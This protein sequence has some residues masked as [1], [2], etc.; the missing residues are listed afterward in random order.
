M[1]Q[2]V[3]PL[4][5]RTSEIIV[6]GNTINENPAAVFRGLGCVT[7]NG[8]SRLLMD[9]KAKHPEVYEEILRQLFAPDYGA[10]LTHI[11]VEFGADINSS[12]GTE[13]CVKRSADEVPDV[14]R[15]AG[16][17]LAADAKRINPAVTADLLRWG[18]PHWVTEAFE[19]SKEAG[20]AAR[21]RWFYETLEAA[22]HTY[23]LTFDYISPDANETGHADVE[24]LL[25]FSKA[26]REQE[27]PPY[28]FSAIRLVASDEVGS[29][30]IAEEK[31]A[32]EALRDAVDVIGLHYTTYGDDN[33]Q[34]LHDVYGKEIWYSEGIAPCNVP[35]L[36]CRADGCG[37]AGPNGPI[38][39]A[40]RII[41]SYVHGRMVMYEFQPAVSAYYDGAC[42]SPKQLITANTPWSGHF[43]RDIGFWIAS[44][45]TCFAKAGWQYVDSACYGDGEEN[46]AIWNTTHNF[47]TLV[48][49]DRTDLTMHISNDSDVP[50]SYLVIISHLPELKRDF[51]FVETAGCSNPQEIDKNWFRLIEE[52]HVNA[53]KGD[54]AFP[55]VVK[56]HSLLTI[57]T[58]DT[59]AIKEKRDFY[60]EFPKAKRLE[61]PYRD[62]FD[63]AEDF[64]AQR[65]GA[66]F[67]TTDQ[68][69]AFEVVKTADGNVLQQ[70]ITKD[71]LPTNW[72]FRGTPDPITC[73]GDDKW[74]NYQ[75]GTR[76][77]FASE[78]PD[79]YA[80]LGMRYNSTVSCPE[81]A[82]CGLMLRL[83]PDGKWEFCYMDAVLDMGLLENFQY[84]AVHELHM[85]AIG[86]LVLAFADGSSVAELRT[87]HCPMI[88]SGRMCLQSA[89]YQNQFLE[90]HA[91]PL[92]LPLPE[93]CWRLDCL[94]P[95][96]RYPEKANNGWTLNGMAEY[97]FFN[98][99]CA[100]GGAGAEVKIRFHGS[101]IF[102]LGKTERAVISLYLDGKLY[103]EQVEVEH[104][105][106]RE[107][108]YTIENI[109][110]TDHTVKL[111]IMEGSLEFD[112][113]EIPTDSLNPDYTPAQPKTKQRT[114]PVTA[115]PARRSRGLAKAAIP[116]AGAAATGL[117]IAFTVGAIVKKKKK[118]K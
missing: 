51:R 36:S 67:L 60:P 74:A 28:D 30:T 32:N 29:R 25:Y 105:G 80:A 104:S 61:L 64:L 23:G 107:A 111:V 49:P 79:N 43:S 17:M 87:E 26:L 100:K 44:H 96:V 34:L 83:Y 6:D 38:D 93:Y 19:E 91:E 62:T 116:I 13:P 58:A 65:G 48:S 88:R 24:W 118:S 68:G 95:Q 14:T 73:F 59:S 71:A 110:L 40:N 15:G 46:H 72:R 109:P 5:I 94:S 50:R 84:D 22:Y 86:S 78:K 102:L 52:T 54:M 41:N 56:P 114:E 98:R 108:F 113:A 1:E 90:V 20:F 11:K 12:S 106:Y 75:C 82:A 3:N 53:V 16:F 115:R 77:R 69:G 4:A 63:Y 39:V 18:E 33:T 81:T 89:Y 103:A 92:P 31:L 97:K 10:G 37:T 101:G 55:V 8:S 76:F 27:D 9:Y 66:P 35:A 57:T 99:T 21:Y 2:T 70:M 47:L 45:F 7:G 117:A 85:M 112:A 42:Y